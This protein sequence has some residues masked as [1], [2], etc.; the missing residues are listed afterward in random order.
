MSK[1][2]N[3]M[4]LLA[5]ATMT[6]ACGEQ[7]ADQKAETGQPSVDA[8]ANGQKS[9]DSLLNVNNIDPVDIA[10]G[11]LPSKTG[12]AGFKA[13]YDALAYFGFNEQSQLVSTVRY[14]DAAGNDFPAI[15]A[16]MT[17]CVAKLDADIAAPCDG[18]IAQSTF[19]NLSFKAPSN[20]VFV[21]KNAT[22]KFGPEPLVFSKSLDRDHPGYADGKKAKPNK[23]FYNADIFEE[24]QRQYV[25]VSN[26]LTKKR[27]SNPNA[28]GPGDTPI[29][30]NET[31]W[32]GLNIFMTVEQQ[33]GKPVR[34]IIDP[35]TGNGMGGQ[36]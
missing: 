19:D 2:V 20:I 7:A 31:Y 25:Y 24:G 17:A 22:M 8:E 18:E 35:D 4:G 14:F 5:V 3:L 33:G 1:T 12:P 10:Y 28:S 23:S 9:L 30:R 29:A 34:I 36:P 21:A 11:D 13:Q 32:Y 16:R 6:S 26:Y 27:G 15:R